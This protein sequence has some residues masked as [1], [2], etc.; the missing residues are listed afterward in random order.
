MPSLLLVEPSGDGW[1][2]RGDFSDSPLTYSSG[3]RAEQ[4]ARDLALRL[5]EAGEPVVLDIRLRDGG[6]AGRFLFPPHEAK[7]NRVALLRA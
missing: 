2:V 5:A 7:T 3:A 1:I 4:A 6:R